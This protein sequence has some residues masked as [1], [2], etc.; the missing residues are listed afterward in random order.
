MTSDK[1]LFPIM[2][3]LSDSASWRKEG[4]SS[5]AKGPSM[6]NEQEVTSPLKEAKQVTVE[7]SSKKSLLPALTD[8]VMGVEVGENSTGAKSVSGVVGD[9]SD[10]N[11]A[12]QMP[13]KESG[14][15]VGAKGGFT[16]SCRQVW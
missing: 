9:A 16:C 8:T 10:M 3:T 14:A 7:G 6:E 5:D 4:G 13:P 11:N 2:K 1:F 12:L 15:L